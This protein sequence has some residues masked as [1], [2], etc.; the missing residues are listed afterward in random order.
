MSLLCALGISQKRRDTPVFRLDNLIAQGNCGLCCH[1]CKQERRGA[2]GRRSEIK[3]FFF[4]LIC[5]AIHVFFDAGHIVYYIANTKYHVVTP[6]K[7][8][9][10]RQ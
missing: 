10:K 3:P 2:G 7:V 4:L 9:L 8:L 6:G 5:P 1:G